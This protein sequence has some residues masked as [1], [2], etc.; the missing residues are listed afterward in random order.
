MSAGR[1][2]KIPG[3]EPGGEDLR[4]GNAVA[5]CMCGKRRGNKN[6]YLETTAARRG[7]K[8]VACS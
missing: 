3:R 7:E 8:L 2:N 5:A 4:P 1:A 6:I